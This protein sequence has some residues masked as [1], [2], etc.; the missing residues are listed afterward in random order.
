MSLSSPRPATYA[1]LFGY[2]RFGAEAGGTR[3][4][5]SLESF[6]EASNLSLSAA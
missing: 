4:A 6:D 3:F 2:A 5:G 1:C